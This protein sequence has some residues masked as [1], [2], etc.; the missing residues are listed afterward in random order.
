MLSVALK[1]DNSACLIFCLSLLICIEISFPEH[2]SAKMTTLFIFIFK[3]F[4]YLSSHITTLPREDYVQASPLIHI[5]L[6]SWPI[7]Q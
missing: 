7:S 5:F 2:N 1:N 3:I 4:I 6:H